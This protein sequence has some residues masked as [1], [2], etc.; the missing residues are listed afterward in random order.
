MNPRISIITV[1]FNSALTIEKTIKSVLNQTFLCSE[2]II[3]DGDSKDETLEIVNRYKPLFE[4]KNIVLKVISERDNG[5]YDA[6]NKGIKN[7][8][9]EIVG[10]LNSDDWFNENAL[11]VVS[12]TFVETN[13]DYFFADIQI[14]KKNG[15]KIIK[16]SKNGKFIT[17]R[18]WNHPTA[19]V[20]KK[21]Y[22]DLGLFSLH[23][24]Y[25]DFDF[26]LRVKKAKKNIVVSNIVLANFVIGGASNKKGL[27]AASMRC[28]NRYWCYRHNGFSRFYWFECFFME[29][30][31]AIIA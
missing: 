23:S 10:I 1:C 3:V 12:N 21:T 7:A 29:I 22:E 30:I 27:K 31:K 6:M 25:D 15:K 26:Y 14:I 8:T 28:K 2:Y 24:L 18:H 19:F 5:I 11:E 9:G 13:F 4:K 17:T 16:H 20:T